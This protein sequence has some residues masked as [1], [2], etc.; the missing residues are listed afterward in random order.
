M[1]RGLPHR[2]DVR[3]GRC[4]NGVQIILEWL[5]VPVG[6]RHNFEDRSRSRRRIRGTLSVDD[7]GSK[8]N[9]EEDG[10]ERANRLHRFNLH[11]WTC[12]GELA[13]TVALRMLDRQRF[14]LVTAMSTNDN[15]L[16]WERVQ[17]IATSTLLQE[18]PLLEFLEGLLQLLLRVH[19]DRS[20]PGHRLFQRLA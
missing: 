3:R 12:D 16:D 1:N 18:F 19:D 14:A 2:P 20:V 6:R 15:L 8:T 4:G 17:E 7:S 10:N 9:N 5:G 13:K 11:G